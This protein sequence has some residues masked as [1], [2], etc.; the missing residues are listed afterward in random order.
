VVAVSLAFIVTDKPQEVADVVF[1]K[2]QL[3]L[4]AWPAEGMF[5]KKE[6]AV[7]FCTLT[8]PHERSL[9]QAV[10][11]ADPRAFLVIG[12]GHQASGGRFG[13]PNRARRGTGQRE[14]EVDKTIEEDGNNK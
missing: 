5:T 11:E 9:R 2:L 14:R 3:G 6:H 4:T 8:R 13:S 10:A 12:H 7:L 1:R